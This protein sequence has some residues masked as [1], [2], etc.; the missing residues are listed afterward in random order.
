MS[1]FFVLFAVE[2]TLSLAPL[3]LGTQVRLAWGLKQ[4]FHPLLP[5]KKNNMRRLIEAKILFR[6]D[7]VKY[8]LNLMSSVLNQ[9]SSFHPIKQVKSV[10]PKL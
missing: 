3:S 10:H 1:G 6:K 4:S 7:L 8:L 5:V 2:G 9:S